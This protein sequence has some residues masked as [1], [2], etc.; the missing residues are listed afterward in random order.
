[1]RPMMLQILEYF[2][3]L[4]EG[5]QPVKS[6]QILQN[7]QNSGISNTSIHKPFK[8]EYT[9]CTAKVTGCLLLRSGHGKTTD[10]VLPSVVHSARSQLLC[11]ELPHGKELKDTSTNSQQEMRPSAHQIAG[12]ETGL[13]TQNVK[14]T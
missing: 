14:P 7:L 13:L 11:C 8:K 2:K 1:M 3:I 4:D 9:T 6:M 12:W 10:S 5:Y